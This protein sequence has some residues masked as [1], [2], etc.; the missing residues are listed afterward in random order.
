MVYSIDVATKEDILSIKND[1]RLLKFKQASRLPR[2]SSETSTAVTPAEPTLIVTGRAVGNA[3]IASSVH[4]N[5]SEGALKDAKH[6]YKL[7]HDHIVHFGGA[8]YQV[9]I[10]KK[11]E[12]VI[13]RNPFMCGLQE[14]VFSYDACTVKNHWISFCCVDCDCGAYFDWVFNGNLV[15]G[16]A[17]S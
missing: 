16:R 4:S 14:I 6:Y 10:R 2:S 11:E 15:Q 3:G 8:S 17:L 1:L 9:V 13:K 7:L 12:V 5:T